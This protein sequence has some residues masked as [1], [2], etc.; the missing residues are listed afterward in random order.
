MPDDLANILELAGQADVRILILDADAP[1]AAGPAA[2]R[3]LADAR[4]ASL[5]LFRSPMPARLPARSRAGPYPQEQ[6]SCS[7]TSFRPPDFEHQLGACVNAMSQDDAI[8]QILVLERMS[9]TLHMRHIDSADLVDT[10]IDD[11]EMVVFRRWQHKRRHVEAR[12]LPASART[13]LRV[14]SLTQPAPF[15]GPFL[16]R[17]AGNR[18]RAKCR[19]MRAGSPAQ[20][21]PCPHVR[22]RCRHMPR[23]P[24]PS[25]LQV[26]ETVLVVFSCGRTASIHPQ[27]VSPLRAGNPLF[28]PQGDSHGPL[29]HQDPDAF[30]C[31]RPCAPQR[32][33]V[34]VPRVRRSAAVLDTGLRHR[35][36]A[37]R[38]QG[39]RGQRQRHRRQAQ[40]QRVRGTRSQPGIHRSQRRRQGACPTL[41]TA[42]L[43]TACARTRRKSVRR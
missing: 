24:R 2:G 37:L 21:H 32:A 43:S 40:A 13:L 36:P 17:R 18:V 29:P 4:R 35:S 10:D 25:R 16:A 3:V 15:E 22:R 20:G 41:R 23:Q 19:F 39:G 26:R 7:P 6:S 27:G 1:G 5:P 38:R 42:P 28:L 33:V 12:V 31:R 11:Y 30:A 34:Q 14:R 9:G 8:G